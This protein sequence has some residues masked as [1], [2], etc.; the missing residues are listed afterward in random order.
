[1]N[2]EIGEVECVQSAQNI[3]CGYKS[4]NEGWNLNSGNCI[5]HDCGSAYPYTSCDVNGT[6]EECK[7]GANF[8]Y[9]EVICNSGYIKINNECIYTYIVDIPVENI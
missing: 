3:Y 1:M 6:C 9:G 8:K 7:S 2:E 5:V 4:C